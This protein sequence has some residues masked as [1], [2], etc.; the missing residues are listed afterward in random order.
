MIPL[1]FRQIIATLTSKE[2]LKK[3]LG[4][5]LYANAYY[6]MSTHVL[7]SLGGFAFWIMA[8]RF[9]STEAV[10]LA[11]AVLPAIGQLAV[12]AELGL[13]FGIIRFLP[14]AGNKAGK[15]MNSC[16]SLYLFGAVVV[17]LIFLFGLELW[18][19]KLLFLRSN[20]VYFAMF[21]FFT[22]ITGWRSL[23]ENIFVALLSSKYTV[24]ITLI[25]RLTSLPLLALFMFFFDFAGIVSAQILPIAISLAIAFIFFLPRVKKGYIPAIRIN[26]AIIKQVI[27]YSFISY[28][29][30]A[31]GAICSMALPL[32]VLNILD[33]ESNAYYRIALT[34]SAVV[35]MISASLSTSAFA[36]SSNR[37][38]TLLSNLSRG[39]LLSIVLQLPIIIVIFFFGDKLLL[40]FG[41]E[42]S[43]AGTTLLRILAVSN[44]PR[45]AISF[46]AT[47]GRVRKN[48][49]III[50]LT[51]ASAIA[52]LTLTYLLMPIL[53]LTG[54][55]VGLLSSHILVCLGIIAIVFRKS[56]RRV[57][58]RIWRGK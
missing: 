35:T 58:S 11:G 21:V 29:A 6:L 4:T 41:K 27:P 40:L 34:M 42:Y 9:Y 38:N 5:S 45:T 39:L 19:P 54:I 14:G 47:Y 53:G 26:K 22:I 49:R 56:P 20:A 55:G 33:A 10:G 28:I 50:G 52:T 43:E 3:H 32:M 8:A 44:I 30:S 13:G 1:Y 23:I 18:S 48:Y 2:G 24:M 31:L 46:Y 36:E 15:M 25:S 16:F 51:V 17:S 12:I 57:L 7:I 37:E